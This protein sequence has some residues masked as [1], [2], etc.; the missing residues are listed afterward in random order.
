M[1]ETWV[2]P[3]TITGDAATK[4]RYL[5]RD[6]IN[7]YF[8]R[9]VIKGN[10]ILFVA[11]RRV[12]KTSIMQDLAENCPEGFAGIYQNIEGV[13]SKNEFYQRLF[14]L[15]LQCIERSK[16]KEAKAFCSDFFK[17]HPINEISS[18]GLKFES[19]ELDYEKQVRHLIP[20]LKKA[21]VHTVIFLDE[22]AEVIHRL[23]RDGNQQDAID[24]LHMLREMR[25]NEGFEHFTLV[26][27]GSIGLE[28]VIR[29]IAR[30]KLINDLHRVITGPLTHEEATRLI[31]QL[32]KTAT[33]HFSKETI[34]HIF[35]KVTYLL[36]YY[37]QLML[38]QIDL[39]AYD[40]GQ[41]V[42][43]IEMVDA[44]FQRVLSRR[45][46]FEDW[47]ERLKDYQGDYFPFINEILKHAA[48]YEGISVKEI[49][50]KAIDPK[51]CRDGDYMDFI[52]QLIDDGYLVETGKQ[53][54]SFISPLLR[55]FWRKKYPMLS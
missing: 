19:R 42:I 35:E 6:Y 7:E 54:Y 47:L 34:D 17:R 8:W 4:E 28:F 31:H 15:I 36:P 43:S 20:E 39:I 44:A 29:T 21:K 23:K 30:P 49:Y 10:H 26:Y 51:F 16:L 24:I 55:E 12:G 33:I 2:H 9:E 11:P 14:E 40:R 48:H 13:K 22:F 50:K 41:P 38:E 3:N 53:V 52:E 46:N 18:A 27:A 45:N 37:L 32:T 5:R 1:K 25:G